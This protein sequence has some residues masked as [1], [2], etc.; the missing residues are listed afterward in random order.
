MSSRKGRT[1]EK[2]PAKKRL[3]MSSASFDKSDDED[4]PVAAAATQASAVAPVF[5]PPPRILVMPIDPNCHQAHCGT[6]R[7]TLSRLRPAADDAPLPP[8]QE[9]V[10]VLVL[11]RESDA[12]RVTSSRDVAPFT[13]CP[14]YGCSDGVALYCE[15]WQNRVSVRDKNGAYVRTIGEPGL[16]WA[17]GVRYPVAA[18]CS[19]TGLVAVVESGQQP[20][21]GRRVSIFRTDGTF[22]T[23]LTDDRF[24]NPTSATFLP[25]GSLMVSDWQNTTLGTDGGMAGDWRVHIMIFSAR[26]VLGKDKK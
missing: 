10:R 6:G 23:L 2:A 3:G 19:Q 1:P 8:I 15:F 22:V 18:A 5:P 7:P 13:M 17:G 26:R 20:A 16:L 14:L 21:C 11:P 4:E 12:E 24:I 9:S 25:D